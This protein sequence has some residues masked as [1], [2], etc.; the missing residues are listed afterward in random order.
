MMNDKEIM[1]KN[2][3]DNFV[4]KDKKQR[5]YFELLDS[6]KRAKFINNLNHKSFSFLNSKKFKKI[7]KEFDNV[8]EIEKHINF[9]K[10]EYYYVISNHND[11][12]DK[13]IKIHDC[14]SEIYWF[15]LA[16]LII[17]NKGDKVFLKM[18]QENGKSEKYIGC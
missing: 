14:F 17:N 2:F 7:E 12:D 9:E 11:F 18:E 13:W 5:C 10:E 4:H 15:G 8:S 16:T 1:I 6:K 3:L